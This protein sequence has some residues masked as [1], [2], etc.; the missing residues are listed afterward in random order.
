M[1]NFYLITIQGFILWKKG[2]KKTMSLVSGGSIQTYLLYL[3]QTRSKKAPLSKSI[4][5]FSSLLRKERS[6]DKSVEEMEGII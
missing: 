6:E 1:N 5:V 2:L 3:E 4:P